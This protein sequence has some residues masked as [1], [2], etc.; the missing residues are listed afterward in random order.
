MEHDPVVVGTL[1]GHGGALSIGMLRYQH[2][3]L[4]YQLLGYAPF[5]DIVAP[6]VRVF[7][8]HRGLRHD[9]PDTEEEGGIAGNNLGVGICPYI[10]Y[11]C[12]IGHQSAVVDQLLQLHAGDDAGDIAALMDSAHEGMVIADLLAFVGIGAGGLTKLDVGVVLGNRLCIIAVA[13][14]GGEN[15]FAA[16]V[17]QLLESRNVS[18]FGNVVVNQQLHSVSVLFL[19]GFLCLNEV[20][21]VGCTLIAYMDEAD[22]H[23]SVVLSQLHDEAKCGC[24][25]NHHSGTHECDF[26]FALHHCSPSL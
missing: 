15:Q 1:A 9:F 16:V 26:V 17:Y 25:D 13:V 6:G 23:H 2:A 18:T 7:H 20:G 12:L 8:Y 10:A 21:G 14:A 19:D 22:P 11:L 3:S 5:D 4:V 24:Q